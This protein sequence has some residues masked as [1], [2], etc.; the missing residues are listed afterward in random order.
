MP[1][2]CIKTGH[3]GLLSQPLLLD[4]HNHL[5]NFQFVK[6][7]KQTDL[8]SEAEWDQNTIGHVCEAE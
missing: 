3:N 8:G 2:K 6:N 1:R 4:I 5:I 7:S